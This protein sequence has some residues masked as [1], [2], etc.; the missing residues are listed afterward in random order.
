MAVSVTPQP[1]KTAISSLSSRHSWLLATF[2]SPSPVF[3]DPKTM[4]HLCD[5]NDSHKN[6]PPSPA[7]GGS[8]S[9]VLYSTI[10]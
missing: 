4:L 5:F 9:W 1:R 6:L 2:A 3:H 8:P 10:R 7:L